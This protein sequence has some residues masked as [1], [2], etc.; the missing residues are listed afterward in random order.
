MRR[1]TL[2]LSL[3]L[4]LAACSGDDPTAP[5][6]SLKPAAASTLE[7]PS[8]SVYVSSD[9]SG[10]EDDSTSAAPSTQSP[11]DGGGIMIGGGG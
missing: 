8:D 3:L 7:V 2:A 5:S 1:F 9:S 6:T 4:A 11:P 10:V